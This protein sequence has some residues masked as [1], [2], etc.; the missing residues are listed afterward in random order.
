ML[1]T[2]FV[3]LAVALACVEVTGLVPGGLIV[4]AYLALYLDQPARVAATLAAALLAFGVS[5]WASARFLLFGRRRFVLVLLLGAL[6]GQ[7]WL[8][9]W[10]SLFDGRTDLR[11]IGWVIPGLLA[12][13]LTRQKLW[14][15]LALAATA[16]FLTYALVEGLR[17]IGL[18]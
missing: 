4:P 5:R 9:V 18:P 7:V 10:P 1:T 16:S 6:F 3:G 17:I 8:L 11:V 12:N 2:I 15:T 14:P 13:N